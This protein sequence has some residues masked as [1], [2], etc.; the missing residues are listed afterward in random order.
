MNSLRCDLPTVR[1]VARKAV[2]LFA[3]ALTPFVALWAQSLR[4]DGHPRKDLSTK[5]I[6]RYLLTRELPSTARAKDPAVLPAS[7]IVDKMVAANARRAAELRGFQGTRFY[8][9]QYH[10]LLG[11]K[12]ASMQVL[13]T[14]A[15][16]DQRN[17]SV[18]SQSGSKLL[19]NRVLLKLLD[20][21]KE[22]FRNQKQVEL[23][24][25]NYQFDL[26]GNERIA[27]GN[28]CYVLSVK[29]RKDNKFLYRGKIWVDASDFA[30]VKM[31]GQPAKS[32]SFW[33]K[34][35]DIESNWGKVG[36]YWLINH[37]ISTSHIRMGGTAVLTIDYAGYKITAI[38]RR[39]SQSGS[40]GPV[41][42][43]PASVTPPR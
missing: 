40:Q 3:C 43:D 39:A 16:P 30:L 20:S 12:D 15:A 14:Y 42:P 27:E 17:Y 37:S 26:V 2:A 18:V 41:V 31:E 38:D 5:D 33:I 35:T 32:P 28:S 29:P 10:G 25:A 1:V 9:L 22:A 21:E 11:A 19:L 8:H 36:E 4:A 7:V 24:P 23:S 34:D 13:A 6:S